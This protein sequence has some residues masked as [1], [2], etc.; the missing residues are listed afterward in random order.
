M[1][2]YV[3]GNPLVKEDSLPLSMLPQ[4]QKQFPDIHFIVVDP[5][6]NFPPEGERDL[7][8][9]DTVKGIS[10]V[11]LLDYSDLAKIEKSPI[12]PHDYDLLLHLL[13]LKKMEKIN[14]VKIIGI[15]PTS[16]NKKVLF[17]DVSELIDAQLLTS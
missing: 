7:I 16:N 6:E 14:I 10:E 4:L 12:S 8:I 11:T 3:F 9:L 17:N 15:P 5:N 13:L 2:I 1:K